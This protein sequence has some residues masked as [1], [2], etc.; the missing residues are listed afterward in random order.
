MSHFKGADVPEEFLKLIQQHLG[1]S[2]QEMGRFKDNPNLVKMAMFFASPEVRS[3]TLVFEVVKSHGCSEGMKVGDKLYFKGCGLLDVQ[4]SS[5]WCAFALSHIST[6]AYTAQN[7]ILQ[8]V[9]PNK[10]YSAYSSC[11]DCGSEF[12]VGQVA[13]KAYIIEDNQ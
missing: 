1:Y 2:D 8:G 12:G 4:R 9:D 5:P 3:K 10:V 7:L 6:F 13:I 11:L